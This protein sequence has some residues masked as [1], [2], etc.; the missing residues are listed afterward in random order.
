MSNDRAMRRAL[1]IRTAF[2]F[3]LWLALAGV[4]PMGAAVGLLAA[5]LAAR[6]SLR[7][8]PPDHW[9][10]RPAALGRL[11]VAFLYQSVVAGIDVAVRAMGPNPRLRPGIVACTLR[12][13]PG[14]ARNLFCAMS[15]L[16]PG[17][18]PTG[19]DAQGRLL[20]HCLDTNQP[21]AADMAREEA[22][23]AKALFV[24]A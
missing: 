18:V 10:V 6:A 22:L 12:T 5:G 4:D 19:F 17:T 15:S 1:V 7:L 24:D 14:T 23:L 9:R 2:L 21:V 20:V 16:L 13:P 8:R 11:A 3:V